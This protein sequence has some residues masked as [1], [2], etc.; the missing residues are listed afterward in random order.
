MPQVFI[1]YST[2]N[3]V[4]AD[5][6]VLKLD[7]LGISVWLD[8]GDLRGGEEW[9]SS[10]D[11]G[12]A[13]SDAMIV[14]LTPAS[15]ASSY[16]T[17]EWGF[18]LGMKK[19]VIPILHEDCQVHPRLEAIQHLDFRD[20]RN[21]QWDVLAREIKDAE[22]HASNETQEKSVGQMSSDDLKEIIASAVALASATSK[23]SGQA[24]DTKEFS[25]AAESVVGAVSRS[26]QRDSSG[27][28]RSILWVDDR[29]NNNAFERQAF[30]ALGVK[31]TLALST[32]EALDHLK[33]KKFSAIISDM[34]RKE[35]PREGYVLLEAVR[36]TDPET[37]FV[38]YAGSNAP[39]HKREAAERGA[40]GSTNS[41]QELFNLVARLIEAH[42]T[43]QDGGGQPAT[44]PKSK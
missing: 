39:E 26:G 20:H 31:F 42:P 41:P 1:S 40:Q 32:D 21:A 27:H 25:R 6:A 33:R 18:A 14:I 34:G 43:E 12:I 36:E 10:I 3:A 28:Q 16:V 38:I 13:Q 15:C 22:V 44:R 5:L 17:Y 7:A 9:R 8:A 24:T 23:A 37:P 11:R 19:K 30:E 35:G 29:P 2:K 4:F